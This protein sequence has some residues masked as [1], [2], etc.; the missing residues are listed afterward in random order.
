[1]E[2]IRGVRWPHY[3]R[4]DSKVAGRRAD[5]TDSSLPILISCKRHTLRKLTSTSFSFFTQPG[6]YPNP[7]P[8]QVPA[9]F[10]GGAGPPVSDAPPWA[11]ASMP[12]Q[13]HSDPI[14][15]GASVSAVA[16]DRSVL[17]VTG[18]Q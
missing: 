15:H 3:G 10:A 13:L 2:R 14:G 7:L 9:S 18:A 5:S 12:H 17:P 11:L 6:F 4:A 1:M 8:M 16:F